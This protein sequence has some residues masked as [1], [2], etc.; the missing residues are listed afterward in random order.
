LCEQEL[1]ER[2][3][4]WEH[5][6]IGL[7]AD[8]EKIVLDSIGKPRWKVKQR[9]QILPRLHCV[10]RE[11]LTAILVREHIVYFELKELCWVN[12]YTIQ[13]HLKYLQQQHWMD[14][15]FELQEK[16]TLVTLVPRRPVH[17][18][19]KRFIEHREFYRKL[20]KQKHPLFI[21]KSATIDFIPFSPVYNLL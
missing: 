18:L 1:Q 20:K 14:I 13:L 10:L 6:R 3:A 4:K 5:T 8:I 19:K 12:T 17:R 9:S 16:Y 15:F 7:A 21:S 11:Y 2:E